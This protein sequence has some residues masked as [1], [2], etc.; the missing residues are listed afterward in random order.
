MAHPG[1]NRKPSIGFQ[2][3][4]LLKG[5]DRC[6]SLKGNGLQ[7]KKSKKPGKREKK[8]K[9]IFVG[10]LFSCE[11]PPF[12]GQKQALFRAEICKLLPL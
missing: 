7:R 2:A 12:F 4:F 9:I 1:T 3:R 10:P 8:C 11:R 6:L 5:L